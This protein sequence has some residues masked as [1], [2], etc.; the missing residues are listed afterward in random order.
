LA[1]RLYDPNVYAGSLRLVDV[2][3]RTLSRECIGRLSSMTG[4]GG[5]LLSD[6]AR[7]NYSALLSQQPARGGNTKRLA[8]RRSGGAALPQLGERP[9]SCFHE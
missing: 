4:F 1:L 8:V 9:R 6:F 3:V 5:G 7:S 2:I